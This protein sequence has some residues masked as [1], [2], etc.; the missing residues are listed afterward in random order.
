MYTATK[1]SLSITLILFD[2]EAIMIM[3]LQFVLG[4]NFISI[5][6]DPIGKLV[7]SFPSTILFGIVSVL[8]YGKFL[9]DARR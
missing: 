4:Q 7:A 3:I 1:A 8:M 9:K 6:N 5:I 2:S